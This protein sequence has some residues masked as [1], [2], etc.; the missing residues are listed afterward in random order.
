MVTTWQNWSGVQCSQPT[1]MLSPK[2][3]NELI[4]TVQNSQKIR[5]VGAGHSFSA[6]VKTNDT[7]VSLDHLQGLIRYDHAQMQAELWAGTRIYQMPKI[8]DPIGQALINQGDIDQQSLAGA[9]ATA[10]HGTG[11]TLQCLSALVEGF[12]LLTAEGQALYCDPQQNAEIFRAGRVSLGSLGIITKLK[13]QNK[14]RY[15]LKEHVRLCAL[16]D[17]LSQM[18]TWRHHYRHIE[19]FVFACHDQVMLKT[20]EETDADPT[21][22]KAEWPS[23]D[24]LLM[25]CCEMVKVFPRSLHFLQKMVGVFIKERIQVNWS[26]QIFPSPRD[27]KFNEMEYQIPIAQGM[28]CLDEVIQAFRSFGLPVFFPIE[29]RYVKGDDI[30]LSPFYQQDSLSI[31]IHQ[32]AKQDYHAIFSK[33]EPIFRRYGG[34]P[35]WGKLHSLDAKDLQTLYPKWQD[36]TQLRAQLDPEQKFINPYLQQ[37][38]IG[39]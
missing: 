11:A 26:G 28:A 9:V 36:F 38:L 24:H 37:L 13:L 35:H 30:W 14:P 25:A 27:T 20:L 6:L 8:L 19:C 12:E 3:F 7:L 2:H 22:K 4:Q 10:T 34:R 15:K 5:V 17:V 16:N 18:D 32:Y 39:G 31:S 29:V 23:E 21:Y 1:S 33:I